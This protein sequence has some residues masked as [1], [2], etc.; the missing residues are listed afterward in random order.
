MEQRA[1]NNKYKNIQFYESKY[2]STKK[3]KKMNLNSLMKKNMIMF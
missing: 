3:Q 1:L 2:T